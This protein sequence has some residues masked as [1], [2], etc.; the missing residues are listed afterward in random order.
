MEAL[1]LLCTTVQCLWSEGSPKARV[2]SNALFR[3]NKKKI[4]DYDY[5]NLLATTWWPLAEFFV[6]SFVIII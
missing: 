1:Y 6:N 2:I 5:E 4:D 3:V